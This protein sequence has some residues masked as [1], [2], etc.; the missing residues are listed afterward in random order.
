[1]IGRIPDASA[2]QCCTERKLRVIE[3]HGP[4]NWDAEF[5][6]SAHRPPGIDSPGKSP[7]RNAIVF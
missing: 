4:I 2:A 7:D 3:N 1:M 6:L 5:L